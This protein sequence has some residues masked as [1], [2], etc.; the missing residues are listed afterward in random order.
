MVVGPRPVSSL[1]RISLCVQVVGGNNGLSPHRWGRRP[2]GML[3]QTV[4]HVLA[5]HPPVCQALGFSFSQAWFVG[6]QFAAWK[7]TRFRRGPSS[8]IL[9]SLPH[10]LPVTSLFANGRCPAFRP[11]SFPGTPDQVGQRMGSSNYELGRM[12]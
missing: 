5:R 1:C 2:K 9:P 11:S 10:F 6:V 12:N 3:F 7:R 8:T 4:P